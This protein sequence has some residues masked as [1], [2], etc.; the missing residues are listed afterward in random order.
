MTI[1]VDMGRK[2]NKQ[3]NKTNKEKQTTFVAIGALRVKQL[4][5]CKRI[6][7]VDLLRESFS[8]YS[9]GI[10]CYISHIGTYHCP[11]QLA[12]CYKHLL[13]KPVIHKEQINKGSYR[14][15]PLVADIEDLT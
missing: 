6:R 14:S 11:G 1:A 7:V 2:T 15:T 13:D 9:L 5:H 12:S 10:L 4:L 3:T 8:T